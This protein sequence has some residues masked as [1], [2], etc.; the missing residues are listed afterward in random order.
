MF[1]LWESSKFSMRKKVTIDLFKK[2]I[3]CLNFFRTTDFS[4]YLYKSLS[5][6]L[7]EKLFKM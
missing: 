3:G 7:H 2:K 5:E 6:H 4:F 1:I